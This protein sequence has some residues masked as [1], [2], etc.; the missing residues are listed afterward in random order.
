MT[1]INWTP[2]TVEAQLE[3]IDEISHATPCLIFKHSTRCSISSVAKN[4]LEK[5]WSFSDEVLPAYYLDLISYRNVSNA[6]AS[7]YG[8]RHESPQVLL[9]KDGRC[10]YSSSHFAIGVNELQEQLS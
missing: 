10:V 5:H 6:I 8:I 2:L 7:R 9:I 3:T 1:T 4:R